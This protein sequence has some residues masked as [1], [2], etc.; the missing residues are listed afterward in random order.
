MNRLTLF[1]SS[2]IQTSENRFVND[3][4]FRARVKEALKELGDDWDPCPCDAHTGDFVCPECE[5]HD[6]EVK[7]LLQHFDENE[8]RCMCPICCFVSEH[9]QELRGRV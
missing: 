3:E 9:L 5:A 8:S 6:P 4:V 1:V 2:V 7:L